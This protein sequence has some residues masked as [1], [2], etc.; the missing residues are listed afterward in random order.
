MA[1]YLVDNRK[2]RDGIISTPGF[3]CKTWYTR[4]TTTSF[5]INGSFN[6]SDNIFDWVLITSIDTRYAKADVVKIAS[7]KVSLVINFA[8]AFPDTNYYIFF[9][10]ADNTNL[11]TVQKYNNRCVIASSGI[12]GNEITWFAIHKTLLDSSGFNST[13]NL[14]AGT[15]TIGAALPLNTDSS[16]NVIDC[17]PTT[18]NNSYCNLSGWYANEYLIQPTLALDGF[19]V[20]PN[21][22]SYSAILSS[23]QNINTFWVNKEPDRVIIGTSYPIPC[24]VDWLMVQTGIDWWNLITN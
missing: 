9:N 13:G 15:R 3:N 4:E 21:L 10:S 5:S 11:Y 18:N 22:A 8:T 16:G 6:G 23:N 1:N 19:Q 17:I 14:F 12:I 24:S 2:V 20:L 7:S